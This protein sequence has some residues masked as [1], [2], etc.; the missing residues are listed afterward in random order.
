MKMKKGFTL[1]EVLITLG[2]IGVVAAIT[3]PSLLADTA[4]AQIGPKLAKAVSMFEQANEGLLSSHVSDTLIDT[5]LTSSSTTYMN[6]F[7][8]FMKGSNSAGT[9]TAKDGVKYTVSFSATAPSNNTDPPHLQKIGSATLDINGAS[10][11]NQ[12]GTDVFYFSMWND[13]SLRPQGGTGWNGGTND[14][15]GGSAHW[16]T[17]C[18][19]DAVASDPAYCAGHIFENNFKVLYR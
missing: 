7:R 11:P 6:E 13:G 9:F 14:A 16:S 18:K 17:K 12:A 8:K 1:A 10:K 2:I 4:S 19:V 5:G 15:S 3:L